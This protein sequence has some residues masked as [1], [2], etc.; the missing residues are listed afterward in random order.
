MDKKEQYPLLTSATVFKKCMGINDVRSFATQKTNAET[1]ETQLLSAFNMTTSIDGAIE[2]IPSFNSVYSHSLDITRL[3]SDKRFILQDSNDSYE[4]DGSSATAMTPAITGPVIHTPIDVRISA[5]DKN[6][7][8]I[9]S[10]PSMLNECIVGTNPDPSIS[11]VF[12]AM[13]LYDDGFVFNG[14]LYVI[15]HDDNR[16]LQYSKT[17]GFDLFSLSDG[18]IPFKRPILQI[19]YITTDHNLKP[20]VILAI[21]SDGV[22]ILRGTN[23]NDFTYRFYPCGVINGTLYSGFISELTSNGHVFLCNDGV[24]FIDP[25]GDV[26]NL[27]VDTTSHLDE[28]NSS[29]IGTALIEGKYFA[30]GDNIAIEYDFVTKSVM[31][32]STFNASCISQWGNDLY[33]ADGSDLMRLDSSIDTSSNFESSIEF[34]YSYM[35]V[36]GGKS[37]IEFLFTGYI[38]GLII[39][40]AIDDNGKTWEIEVEELGQCANRRIKT[41]LKPLGSYVSISITCVSGAFRLEELKA[42]LSESNRVR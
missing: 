24:Y 8:S 18:F 23:A 14:V 20:G 2:K 15:S 30:Y 42:T 5:S 28:L 1:G 19:G 25:D 3:S 31:H 33:I 12:S 4:W 37:I 10:T 17:Y 9:D 22:S 13:P 27:T 32:R 7:K 39:I 26:K 41:P 38:G 40:K 16:F 36:N 21:H 6:Y 29:Y 35:G 11:K 34:P